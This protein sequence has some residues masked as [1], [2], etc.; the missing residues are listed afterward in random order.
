MLARSTATGPFSPIRT[1]VPGIDICELFPLQ[2]K[3][4]HRFS[5]VRSLHH[6]MAAHSDGAV[7]ANTAE[8]P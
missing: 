3:L 2:A 1:T 7:A 6:T 5:L 4:A 8:I